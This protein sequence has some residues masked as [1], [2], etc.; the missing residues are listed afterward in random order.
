MVYFYVFGGVNFGF[1]DCWVLF[2]EVLVGVNIYV[3]GV[4]S[5]YGL[6][7]MSGVVF[8]FGLCLGVSYCFC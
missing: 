1:N 2:V 4:S 5:V 8:G 3:L 7:L 6:D